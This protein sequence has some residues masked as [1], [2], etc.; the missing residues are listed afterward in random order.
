MAIA[1]KYASSAGAGS[2]D[3]SS[4]GNAWDF[5][6]MLTTAAA[7]DRVNFKGSHSLASSASFT[8]AGTATSPIIIRGYG[9]TIGDGYQGRANVNGALIT[10]NFATFVC[11]A[12]N[13]FTPSNFMVLECVALTSSRNGSPLGS[14]SYGGFLRCAVEN[15][16]TG[17]S[18][19]AL[20]VA[21]NCFA[22][23]CD[24]TLSGASGGA[25]AMTVSTAFAI[26]CR[27]DGGP[28]NACNMTG[29]GSCVI[30]C[31]FYSAG[32]DA[33]QYTSASTNGLVC[34]CTL[35]GATSDGFH[36]ITGPTRTTVLVNNLIVDNG[37]YGIYSVDAGAAIVAVGNRIA[38]NATDA[39]SGATDWLAA[40]AG[41]NN[42]TSATQA[43]EFPGYGSDDFRLGATS[44]A[45][46][47]GF[48]LYLDIGALQRI[49]DYPAVGNVQNDDTVDGATGTLTL[50]AVE[51][52]ESGVQYG[53]GGTEFT[54][55]LSGGSATGAYRTTQNGI[56][57]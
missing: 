41:L 19:S 34:G 2:K 1:E 55:T 30:H 32:G 50:P 25:A 27:A 16:G 4:E 52:V 24:A 21:A 17:S 46:Q 49:E 31:T 3:G 29:A 45:R 8:S 7:G 53:A 22:V 15:N 33:I 39:T 51:D 5:A 44:P 48:P 35:V 10:T 18:A 6:T 57:V 11:G 20:A 38:R 12:S 56:G 28:A 23:D 43:N 47:S 54:G 40:F 9:T 14:F 37:A 26:G 13:T 42:T 36:Q